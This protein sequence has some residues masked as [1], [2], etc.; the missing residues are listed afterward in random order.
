[1]GDCTGCVHL[2]ELV[3][4]DH[5]DSNWTPSSPV[6]PMPPLLGSV[7]DSPWPTAR[8][9][10]SHWAQQG[11]HGV[12][13]RIKNELSHCNHSQLVAAGRT[14]RQLTAL[15]AGGFQLHT[16]GGAG[17]NGL[18]PP[19]VSTRWSHDYE[20][21]PSRVALQGPWRRGLADRSV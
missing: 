14:T 21:A 18:L 4:L 13:P 2:C 9:E 7:H 5:F 17:A 11:A 20:A 3:C 8:G 16:F 6:M 10:A 12:P 1:M 15:M 19:A